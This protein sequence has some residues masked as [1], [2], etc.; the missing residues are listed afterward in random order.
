MVKE[1]SG[2]FGMASRGNTGIIYIPADI[3]KD[4]TFPLQDGDQVRITIDKDRLI[5][6]RP[7]T[8]KKV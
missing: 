3:V 1:N 4:S 5:I 8:K 6:E 2:R 7:P